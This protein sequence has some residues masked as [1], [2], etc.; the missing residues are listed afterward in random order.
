MH[1]KTENYFSKYRLD[2]LIISNKINIKYLSGFSWSNWF[3]ILWKNKK[4]LVT[5]MRYFNSEKERAEKENTWFEILDLAWT[6]WESTLKSEKIIWIES[7]D[8]TLEKF[9]IWKN[10][11]ENKKWIQIK[12]LCLNE[13]LIKS[14]IEIEKMKK[15]AK[16]SE[17]AFKKTI[18]KIKEW[19]SEKELAREFEKNAKEFWAEKLSFWTIIAF[20]KNSAN[21]HH[22]PTEK[23]LEKW[24]V[25][26]IDFWIFYDWYASDCT[27]TFLTEKNDK[28]EKRYKLVLEAQ[29]IACEKVKKWMKTSEIYQISNNIFEKSKVEKYFIHSLWHGIWLEVHETPNISPNNWT[30]IKEWMVFTIEPWLYFEGKFWIRIED[31]LVMWK[32]WVENFYEISKELEILEI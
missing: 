5:D 19:I 29:K 27:R 11:F 6:Q 18:L 16:I 4:Y 9:K 28:I 21:P 14:K 32:N 30:E 23:K 7:D 17:K 3:L 20:W 15:A 1:I 26:L 10:K 31:T 13:R 22:N 24:D 25:I 2:F 8:F 12:R